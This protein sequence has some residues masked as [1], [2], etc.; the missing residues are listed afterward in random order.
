MFRHLI[1]L[2]LATLFLVFGAVF[3]NALPKALNADKGVIKEAE[4]IL[5]GKKIVAEVV[6][7]PAARI[8]G[9]SGRSGLPQGRGMLF[10]FEEPAMQG[11]WMKDMNFP[12]DIVWI[13]DGAVVGVVDSAAPD[14]RPDRAVYY[15]PV[16]V[17]YVLELPAGTALKLGIIP[18]T[19]V[20]INLELI[21]L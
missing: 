8:R 5:S 16:P 2:S 11:F 7:T 13:Q 10:V 14:D 17:Q 6:D 3:F 4:V 9:L 19:P 18:G 21:N 1:I 15:S 20:Q 12:I